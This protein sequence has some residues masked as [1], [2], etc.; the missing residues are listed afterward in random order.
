MSQA[1]KYGQGFRFGTAPDIPYDFLP[2]PE[3]S[4]QRLLVAFEGFLTLD[5]SS[6]ST[7]TRICS[8]FTGS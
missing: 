1:L 7:N 8:I 3:L 5:A 2:L 6:N 4:L